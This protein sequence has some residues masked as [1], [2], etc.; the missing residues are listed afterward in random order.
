M[1]N[2][3]DNTLMQLVGYRERTVEIAMS[4]DEGGLKLTMPEE[5]IQSVMR[6][7][8]FAG[9]LFSQLFLGVFWVYGGSF[10]GAGRSDIGGGRRESS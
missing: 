1:R 7:G 9:Q 2:W 4:S 8:Y 6:R 5:T 10:A 3:N